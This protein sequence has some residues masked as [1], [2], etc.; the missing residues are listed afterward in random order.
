MYIEKVTL[1]LETGLHARP[2]SALAHEASRYSSEIRLV[3]DGEEFNAKCIMG[4]L[5]LGAAK[6]DVFIIKAEG[7]D[8]KEAV[9]GIKY[10]I[11]R[12]ALN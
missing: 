3:K 5:S 10:I 4:L 6:G 1:Q 7:E 12:R 2:A 9:E 8:A 11:S